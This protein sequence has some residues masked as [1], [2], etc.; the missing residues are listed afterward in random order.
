MQNRRKFLKSSVL[1]VTGTGLAASAISSSLSKQEDHKNE[2]EIVYRTLGRTGIKI[3]IVSMGTGNTSNP[4][5]IREALAKGIKLF[6]TSEYYQNGNN[7]KM[8]GEVFKDYSRDSFHIITGTAGGIVLDYANGV[9]KPETDPDLFLE[10]ADGC[11]KRL[12][13]DYVDIFN[14]G[15]A[16]RKESVYYEPLLKAMEKFKKQ[17]KAKYLGIATHKF[18]PEAIRAAADVGIY[19]VIMTSYNFRKENIDEINEAIEYATEKGMG[20]IAMK[21][22]AGVYWDKEK[23]KPI[24]TR[25]ALK[26]VLA[27]KNIHTSV[28]DCASFDHLNQDIE[29]MSDLKL[30]EEEE[31]H[32]KQEPEKL[33]S[34]IY[35]QQCNN[36]VPQCP[37]NVDIPTIMRSYMYAYGH[38]NLAHAQNTLCSSG[39]GSVPCNSCNI[40]NVK[41]QV[42]FDIKAKILDIS[43]LVHVP[44]DFISKV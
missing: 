11:L 38:Q 34:G 30:T 35:C 29:I 23:T 9:F 21:T 17:G 2:N 28:P 12:Q 24:N 16:A 39:L 4:N 3:P 1:A 42:G 36:C 26:F 44:E 15:F 19:D 10:H 37:E 7:E 40:C 41:C 22:M 20:I 32:I 13:V 18:E 43:R 31:Q 5:L 25:A 33:A 8:L 14:L 6:A 27:N